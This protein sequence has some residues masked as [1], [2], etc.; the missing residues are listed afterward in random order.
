[1]LGQPLVLTGVDVQTFAQDPA[2]VPSISKVG[3][4]VDSLAAAIRQIKIGL[5]TREGRSG[6]IADSNV[7][8]RDLVA[9]GIVKVSSAGLIASGSSTNVQAGSTTETIISESGGG[10]GAS[11][12]V[13][14]GVQNGDPPP[15]PTGLTGA[16]ALGCVILSW[17]AP[18]YSN[19]AFTKIYRSTTDNFSDAVCIGMSPG[20][21]FVDTLGTGGVTYYYWITFVTQYPIEGPANSS[22]TAGLAATPGVDPTYILSLVNS[23][24]VSDPVNITAGAFTISP[25]AGT[26]GVSA[27]NPFTVITTSTVVNGQTVPPGV[28]ITNASIAN[29]TIT[30]AKIG[31]A[32]ITQA[33]IAA[34]AIGNAQIGMAAI[35]SANIQSAAVGLAQINTASI[36][37][38][39]AINAALGAISSGNI[40]LDSSS[41]IRGGQTAYNTGT[42]FFLGYDTTG[43]SSAYKLSIGNGTSGLLWNGS[44][45]SVIG[46]G[47]FTGTINA[48]TGVVTQLTGGAITSYAWP[49]AGSGGFYIGINGLLLGNYNGGGRYLQYYND[50]DSSYITTNATLSAADGTFSGTLTAA[51]VNA[52]NTINIAGN[53]VTIAASAHG[54]TGTI[55]SATGITSVG[56]TTTGGPVYLNFTG[57]FQTTWTGTEGGEGGGGSSAGSAPVCGTIVL[58]RDGTTVY[59]LANVSTLT[60]VDTPAAGYHAWGVYGYA[61]G[62]EGATGSVTCYTYGSTLF[63]LETRR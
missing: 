32:A 14:S 54:G 52:V 57:S 25:P 42:G 17:D 56:F 27:I 44:A 19:P 60:Y 35:S 10:S 20:T 43:G 40:T 26:S 38:L 51:A 4:T 8:W 36:G 48:T 2:S 41:Y 46:S 22:A 3:N 6:S 61:N 34:A 21:T 29:G 30:T 9:N 18:T 1:M 39:S 15:A 59:S 7:T 50:G 49:A 33:L 5:D 13:S 23:A 45:L 24:T 12:D 55:S 37:S 53:A 11:V 31:T 28:Y 63:A 58:Q 16:G 62:A 47:T